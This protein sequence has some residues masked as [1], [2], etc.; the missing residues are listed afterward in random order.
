MRIVV[1]GAGA[2]GAWTAL[3]LRRRGADVTLIDQYGPGSTLATSGD[4]TRVTR[5]AHGPN[6]HYPLWQRRALR[7]WTDLDDELYVPTGVLWLVGSEDGGEAAALDLLDRAG[8]PIERVEAD[9]IGRRWPQIDLEGIEW[10][11]HEPEGG[12]LM[13]RRGVQSVARRFLADGGELR[14]GRV[15]LEGDRVMLGEETLDS[16]GFVFAAGPWLPRLLGPLP[17]L[18]I[19]VP[20]QEIVYFATP[21]GSAAYDA[22]SLPTWVEYGASIYGLPSIDGRGFKVAPDWPGP[23]IDPDLEERRLSDERVA[24]ARDYLR[25]RFPA[26]AD[27]PVVGG[28]VCQYELT[29]DTHFIIDRH[30]EMPGSWVVGGGSGH[31]FK[32]APV[33]GE[34]VAALVSGDEALVAKLAPPDDRFAFGH[35]RP[36]PACGP[37]PWSGAPPPRRHHHTS[38]KAAANS[39][40]VSSENRTK[41]ATSTA[42]ASPPRW[43]ATVATATRAPS[44]GG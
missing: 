6:E 20:R 12:A 22:G 40:Y 18:A 8:I 44:G 19:S 41:R 29:P 13:A 1:V 10:G 16:D 37:P 43:P 35:A 24:A 9:E 33:V 23:Q 4:E 39:P 14:I 17:G 26:L 7:H 30:P 27:Q 32:H 5:S 36:R 25:R 2:F 21:A 3:W 15:R 28:R 34:Y 31:G 11:L 38:P 42:V